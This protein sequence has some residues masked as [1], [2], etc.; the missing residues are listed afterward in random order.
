MPIINLVYEWYVPPYSRKPN[1]NTLLYLPL[2]N[3]VVD[4]SW[5]TPRTFSTSWIT[6]TTV[7]WIKSAYAW[8]ADYIR[9]TDPY[10]LQTDITKPITISVLLYNTTGQSSV[11]RCI[12]DFWV[13]NGNRLY[14]VYKENSTNIQ[15][16]NQE[17]DIYGTFTSYTSQWMHLV[18]TGSKWWYFKMYMNWNLVTTGSSVIGNP[19]WYWPNSNAYQAILQD[20]DNYGNNRWLKGNARELIMEQVEW[21]ADDVSNYYTWIKAKLWF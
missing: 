19:R 4:Q 20:R 7:W 13:R 9:L 1:A 2:E 18:I 21:S 14:L 16:W 15:R 6:F 11:R 17:T 5:K 10:P 12:V 8:D 3:D